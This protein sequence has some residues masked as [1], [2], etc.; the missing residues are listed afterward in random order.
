MSLT[1]IPSAPDTPFNTDNY[2]WNIDEA[3]ML[4]DQG[5]QASDPINGIRI[6]LVAIF[7]QLQSNQ[8]DPPPA[9]AARA[10]RRAA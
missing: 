3:T 8:A 9:A 1:P 7:L 5:L 10:R 2:T 6:V 4:A